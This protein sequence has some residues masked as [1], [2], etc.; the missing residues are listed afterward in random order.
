M[1]ARVLAIKQ[2]YLRTATG[3]IASLADFTYVEGD[4]VD[5]E[6][7]VENPDL[8]LY[9]LDDAGKRAILVKLSPG[10]DLTQV[11]FV[12][13]AQGE[14]AERLVA[15][16]YD[17]FRQLDVPLLKVVALW[18]LF[19]MEACLAQYE[20][21][22]RALAVR[23]DDLNGHREAVVRKIFAYCGLPVSNVARALKAFEKDAQAGT[24]LARENATKGNALKLSNQQLADVYNVLARHPVINTPNFVL[25]GTLSV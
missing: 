12:Y 14:R 16:A 4:E 20:R 10:V 25:P 24:P 6:V 19:H 11:P 21:G 17:D 7:V 13:Q 23:Y 22:V 5:P 3:E 2:R 18:W 8:S 15:V 9:C 1:S